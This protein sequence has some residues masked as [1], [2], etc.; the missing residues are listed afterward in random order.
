MPRMILYPVEIRSP[1]GGVKSHRSPVDEV[2]S[3]YAVLIADTAAMPPFSGRG[4]YPPI[5]P[6]AIRNLKGVFTG[7]PRAASTTK[8][9]EIERII[10]ATTLLDSSGLADAQVYL[11][12]QFNI[13]V[14]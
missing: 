5:F 2:K 8:D 3:Y 12:R 10:A 6:G 14:F 7:T 9:S 1:L 4:E 11:K 13:D